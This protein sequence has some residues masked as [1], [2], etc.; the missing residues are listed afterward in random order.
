VRAAILDGSAAGDEVLG[1]AREGL[2]TALEASGWELEAFTLRE[3][4]ITWCAGCFGCWVKTPGLCV[5]R[6]DAEAIA[7]SFVCSDLAIYLTRVTFG[8]YSSILKGAVDRMIGLGSPLFQKVRGE[9]HHR[10]RYDRYPSLVAVGALDRADAESEAL[11]NRLLSRN[12]LNAFSPAH[13]AG[14]V[15]DVMGREGVRA[16]VLDAL[17][18]AGV[19]P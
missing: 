8:G 1:L 2:V 15:Y 14:F 19:R 11:F 9:V 7:R 16:V 12:A 4:D 18:R 10:R 17:A 13:A 3:M 5:V 6:D